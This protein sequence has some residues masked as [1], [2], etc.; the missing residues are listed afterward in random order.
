MFSSWGDEEKSRILKNKGQG[1]S[2]K[3]GKCVAQN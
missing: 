2:K 1:D 3:T